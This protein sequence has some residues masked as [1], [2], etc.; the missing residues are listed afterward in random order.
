MFMEG[1]RGN[2]MGLGVAPQSNAGP[3]PGVYGYQD[4][5]RVKPADYMPWRYWNQA[6]VP[7]VYGYQDQ[8]RV[9]T[10]DYMPW[11][12]WTQVLTRGFNVIQGQ[13]GVKLAV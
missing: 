7:G 13:V 8:A 1:I 6:P 5:A 4:Q 11:R 9:K 3:T 12:Y 2:S 10:A